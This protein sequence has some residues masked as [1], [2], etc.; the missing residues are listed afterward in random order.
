LNRFFDELEQLKQ[1]LLEMSSLV[2]ANIER[3][4]RAVVHKDWG[5]A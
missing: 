3:S 1:K 4:V 5:A 2:E